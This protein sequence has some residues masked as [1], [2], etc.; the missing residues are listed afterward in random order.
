MN[1]E[2]KNLKKTVVTLTCIVLMGTFGFAQ[3]KMQ[4]QVF[5]AQAMGQGTQMGRSV[6]ITMTVDEYSAPADQQILLEAFEKD[7]NRGL[8]NALDKMKSKGRI[9]ITGTLGFD[10]SYVREFPSPNGRRIRMITDRVITFR[11]AWHQGRSSDYRLS[12]L[13]LNL[14]KDAKE[15]T[16]VLMPLVEFKIDKKAKQ[17]NL[18]LFQNPWK[19]VNVQDRSK[20]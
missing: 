7:G 13:E 17:I 3:G 1:R 10:I 4:R 14:S 15:N 12:V 11:E 5:Q 6:N 2:I 16:G 19:L 20:K 18:E 8:V 9:A